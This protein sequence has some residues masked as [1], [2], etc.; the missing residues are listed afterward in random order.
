MAGILNWARRQGVPDVEPS[1]DWLGAEMAGRW[2][3]MRWAVA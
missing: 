2:A 3:Y 1:R